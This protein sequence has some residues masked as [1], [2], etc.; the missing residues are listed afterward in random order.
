MKEAAGRDELVARGLPLL[1]K[2]YKQKNVH[3]HNIITTDRLYG[4]WVGYSI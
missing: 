3:S 4:R 2:C 1:L